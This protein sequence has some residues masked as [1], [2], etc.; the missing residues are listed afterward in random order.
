MKF[1]I[2]KITLW[3]KNNAKPRT[4]DF[5]PNK[6]NVITGG[7]GT[8]KSS[9]LSIFDYCMLSTKANIAEEVINENV[10]WYGLD[11]RINDKD[12]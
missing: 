1:H 3:F 9:I 6:V 10:S 12:F 7:S 4:I 5:L 11:F 2:N 8:G